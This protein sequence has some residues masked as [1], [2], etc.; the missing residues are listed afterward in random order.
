MHLIFSVAVKPGQH[1]SVSMFN[2]E[3]KLCVVTQAQ[4]EASRA[5][6][7]LTVLLIEQQSVL[8]ADG[9]PDKALS[10]LLLFSR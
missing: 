2:I 5:A 9:L 8:S 6:V 3:D 1:Q 7:N 10:S 4:A